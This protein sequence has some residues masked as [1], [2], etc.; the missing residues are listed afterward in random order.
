LQKQCLAKR[1]GNQRT[2][3]RA[4]HFPPQ[5]FAQVP[6]TE[7]DEVVAVCLIRPLEWLLPHP[8]SDL[9]KEM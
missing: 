7:V 5:G 3:A 8:Q 2:L 9:L 6:G 4:S 1:L